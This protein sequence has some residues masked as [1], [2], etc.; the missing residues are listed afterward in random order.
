MFESDLKQRNPFGRNLEA[1]AGN[2]SSR[3]IFIKPLQ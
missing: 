2:A 3:A 1:L